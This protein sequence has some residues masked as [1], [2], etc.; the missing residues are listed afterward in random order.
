MDGRLHYAIV[1][2]GSVSESLLHTPDYTGL[3]TFR[4]TGRSLDDGYLCVYCSLEILS[5]V[6]LADECLFV[7]C[8]I[9]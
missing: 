7:G 5:F 2:I 8:D 4:I 6:S 9:E 1:G 3:R